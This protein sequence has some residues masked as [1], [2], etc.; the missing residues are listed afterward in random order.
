MSGPGRFQALIFDMDGVLL[1]SEP[2]YYRA[3]N[4][5]L[6]E[7]GHIL[8]EDA[9]CR[10][11]GTSGRYASAWIVTH[12]RLPYS[13]EDWQ[14]R[15]Q[16]AVL[17]ALAEPLEPLPGARELIAAARL[18]GLLLGLASA[19]PDAWIEAILRGLGLTEAFDVIVS[20][21]MVEQGKP[22]P[23]IF[24]LAAARLGVPAESC[25]VIEDSAPGIRA[26]RAAG[27]FTVQLRATS[28]AAPPLPEADLVLTS[29]RAFPLTLLDRRPS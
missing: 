12:F 18:R 16:E 15:Y 6:A 27:M 7:H 5:L 25:L 17:R 4:L 11:V 29:L 23:D 10:L 13:A 2:Y 20:G 3:V 26:A 19:S 28:Y 14:A 22:A 1:D 24:L 21:T 9:Y 8:S